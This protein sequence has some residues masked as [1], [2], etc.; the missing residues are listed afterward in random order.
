MSSI[1]SGFC[2]FLSVVAAFL[3]AIPLFA[4]EDEVAA[5]ERAAAGVKPPTKGS[6]M[7]YG[8]VLA[9]GVQ[10]PGPK[11]TRYVAAKGLVIRV[12]VKDE[13]YVC[14]DTDT[15]RVAAAWTRGF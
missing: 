11:E 4:V 8:P 15:L 14:F 12:G 5:K 9:Y 6:E 3:G 7:Q 13:A 1:R 2:L 10:A